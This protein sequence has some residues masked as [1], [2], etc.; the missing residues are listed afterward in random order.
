M[1]RGGVLG[2]S[3]CWATPMVAALI[4]SAPLVAGAESTGSKWATGHRK[5]LVIPVRFTDAGGPSNEPNAHGLSGWG[6]FT[7]GTTT[8]GIS[9]FFMRQSYSQ[10]SLE[11]TILPEVNL[12]VPSTYYTN[13][14][15]GTPH[16]KWTDWGA[17]G[18]LADDARAKA[19]AIGL[20]NG[21]TAMYESANYDFD[22]IACGY[23]DA[24]KAGAASDGGRSVLAFNFNAIPHEQSHCLGLQHANGYS[25]ASLYSPVKAGSYY[26]DA[27]GDVYC[28]MGWKDNT[29]T[30]SPAPDRDA[31]VYFKYELGWL[32]TNHIVTPGT[33]GTYRL[34]AYDQGAL[35]EGLSYAMRIARD[36]SHT[37]WFSFRQAIT[38]A[39]DSTWSQHGLEVRFGAESPRTSSGATVL[40]DM[41]P[42]SRGALGANYASPGS[43]FATMRDA[44][45]QQGRT[46]SDNEAEI[47][48]TPIKKGG[49]SPESLDVVVHFGS[50]PGNQAP[51]VSLAPITLSL[52]A[53]VEQ[54]FTATASD[55]DGDTLAYYWEF[56]DNTKNGG[57]DFG[58]INTDATL[59]TQG[60]H[61]W[62]QNGKSFVRCTVSDMKGH[63]ATASATVMVTNGTS[64]PITISGVILDEL[65]SP[66]E[67]ALVNNYKSG[68]AYGATN[69]A[70][71]SV[72]A[73][74]GNYQIAL[75][76]SNTTYKLSVLYKGYS[77]TNSQGGAVTV[78]SASSTNVN[79][80]RVR[81]KCLVSGGVYVAGHGYASSNYGDL[82][83][84][85]GSH[86]VLVTNGSWSLSID[87]GSLVTLTA[88]TT[89][90]SYG[91]TSDIPNPYRVVDDVNTLAF[92]VDIPG[93]MPLTGFTSS[94]T[95]SDDTVGTVHIPVVMTLPPGV[96]N[97]G[98]DQVFACRVDESS[99]AEYGV[100]YTMSGAMIN[101]YGELS[102]VPYLLPLTV[103]PGTE[104]KSKTV[105]LQLLP[106]SSVA[107]LGPFA[108]FTYTITHAGPPPQPASMSG[109][110]FSNGLATFHLA[111]LTAS[112]TN[113]LLWCDDL[114][115]PLWS[116]DHVFTG[117]SGATNWSAALSPVGDR[118]FYRIRSE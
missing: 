96:T 25:R 18:S 118:G 26:Y 50:F 95:N 33:S 11:F 80:M 21:L 53:G 100:D 28:L 101:F 98:G 32:T 34:H 117:V 112:A 4:V 71:S 44:P 67:G 108:T 109:L 113:Y 2:K 1:I 23:V 110:S 91:V 58:G 69:F 8:A 86:S 89:N 61:A 6:A 19:R 35:T 43:S 55:P 29:R 87:D 114:A 38:N 10:L 94:G 90:S 41:T 76:S 107:N 36:P 20:T 52:A 88:T 66:L 65:G 56:D 22:L 7:N 104:P 105:V 97:W 15:P 116:T 48:V 12:G 5:V 102:P 85:D 14:C 99:T 74:D 27:Y 83:V 30:A 37:Y 77:F 93:A 111:D 39:P 60:R 79:F 92:F 40:L 31:N 13:I 17:P 72:T 51:I 68:V 54:T 42:G 24:S 70:G 81:K 3:S 16:P 57:T 75:P 84:S 115:L 78:A 82:W 103:I 49:T 73:A 64:A 63:V 62:T 46:Y 106:G 59:A 9:N 45:L 47:H